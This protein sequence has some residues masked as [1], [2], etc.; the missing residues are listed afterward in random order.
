M[1]L[2]TGVD[3]DKLLQCAASLPDLVGHEVPGAVL[4]AGKA[5]RRYPKPKWMEQEAVR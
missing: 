3:L 1:G 4:K 2:D 5:D